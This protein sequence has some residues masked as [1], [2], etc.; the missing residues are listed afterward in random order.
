MNSLLIFLIIGLIIVFF[1]K[2][3]GGGIKVPS[4]D[5]SELMMLRARHSDLEVID[6]RT[7]AEIARG[8]M[9]GAH[10]INF[11]S[12]NFKKRLE[13]LPKDR[14]YL[15]YCRS[16]RRSASACSAMLEMGFS[17]VYNLRGGYAG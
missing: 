17:Q 5:S 9:K 15:V 12:S 16:G 4:I 1:V 11:M 8:K 3:Q 2:F 7:P 10:E 13:H 6:V 14:P